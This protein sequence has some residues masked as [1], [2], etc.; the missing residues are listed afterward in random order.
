MNILKC[1]IDHLI[2][3]KK[4]NDSQIVFSASSFLFRSN[5]KLLPV[6]LLRRKYFCRHRGWDR[7][8][9][10]NCWW[11]SEWFHKQDILHHPRRSLRNTRICFN[12]IKRLP[13]E[14]LET[15]FKQCQTSRQKQRRPVREGCLLE[16]FKGQMQPKSKCKCSV[17]L[18]LYSSRPANNQ[19][20]KPS[21][22][23][24]WF[25]EQVW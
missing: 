21:D 8:S 12:W 16:N 9:P 25:R 3:K 14:V 5:W 11:W 22:D 7:S 15:H 2:W 24:G 18:L 13:W 6:P 1:R 4:K 23:W 20:W 10:N 17:L 19:M